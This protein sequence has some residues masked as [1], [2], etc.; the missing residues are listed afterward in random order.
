MKKYIIILSAALLALGACTNFV[1]E[2]KPALDTVGAPAISD[3]KMFDDSLCFTITPASGTGYYSYLVTDE[4][5]T[6]DPDMLISCL[7][8]G[9]DAKCINSKDAATSVIGLSDLDFN[10]DYYI[11]AVGASQKG[12]L[13]EV[14]SKQVKTTD[15]V[16]PGFDDLEAEDTVVVLYFTEPVELASEAAAKN[17]VAKF[18]NP[19]QTVDYPQDILKGESCGKGDVEV[20]IDGEAVAFI[21]SGVPA[22]AYYAISFPEG[23]FVDGIGNPCP[24]M[25]ES[26]FEYDEDEEEIVGDLLWGRAENVSFELDF[27]DEP[28]EVVTNLTTLIGVVAPEDVS[29]AGFDDEVTGTALY[30]GPTYS[31]TYTTYYGYDYLWNAGAKSLLVFPHSPRADYP[32]P[33]R[34]DDVSLIIPAGL[35]YDAFGNENE[36]FK[37]GPFLYSYGYTL[38]DLLGTYTYNTVSYYG[39]DYNIE[40][41]RLVI[42]ESDY[43]PEEGDEDPEFD[44][45]IAKGSFWLGLPVMSPIY[46]WFDGDRG[47]VSIPDFGYFFSMPDLD[48]NDQPTGL[49]GCYGVCEATGLDTMDFIFS[50]GTS[51]T[52]SL[53]SGQFAGCYCDL[54][55]GNDEYVDYY[56]WD[57]CPAFEATKQET[58]G[59]GGGTVPIIHMTPGEKITAP[60]GFMYHGPR[61][62]NKFRR[63]YSDSHYHGT[64][65][66]CGCRFFCYICCLVVVT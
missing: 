17:I 61:D 64:C 40:G 3:V 27:A 36:E 6:P 62:M 1:E 23:T 10:T 34:G 8:E 45:M 25:P 54:Y 48:K 19:Y 56:F 35:L 59:G 44:F 47:I 4:E 49:M 63:Y 52:L 65:S 66:F 29:I 46:G 22:G 55:D 9:V 26:T 51:T 60:D 15:L 30:E 7:I 43:E 18:Y 58:S 53:M 24:A 13:S 21:V 14:V 31:H 57:V 37:F 41:G 38:E 5:I 50:K 16:A 33:E 2:T 42:V 39:A 12:V 32:A 28:V 20:E 11:Y